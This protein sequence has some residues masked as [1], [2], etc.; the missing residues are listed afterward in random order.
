MDEDVIRIISQLR[1]NSIF[2]NPNKIFT[3]LGKATYVY[4]A[5][6][7]FCDSS[8][9]TI[10]LRDNGELLGRQ[11]LKVISKAHRNSEAPIVFTNYIL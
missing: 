8:D 7:K 10:L 3:N 5:I 2:V 6:H 9:L 1:V 11:V 4:S